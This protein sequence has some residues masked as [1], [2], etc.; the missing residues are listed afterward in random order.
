MHACPTTYE[1]VLYDI[2]IHALVHVYT[3]ILTY[4]HVPYDDVPR[5]YLLFF[6]IYTI[7]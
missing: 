2:C 7:T 5:Q 6:H 1:Y 4:I 3:C